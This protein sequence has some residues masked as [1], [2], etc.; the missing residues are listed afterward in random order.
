[1]P[2]QVVDEA[3]K[4]DCLSISYTY[5]EPTIFFEY[6]YDTARL[7]KKA[8]LGNI[9]VTN[10]FM[11]RQALDTI[12]P[13]LDAAN[14]DLKSYSEV[15]YK[16]NCKAH[17]QPVLDSIA[18]MKHLNIWVEVTTLVIPDQNDSEEELNEIASFIAKLDKDIPW[19]ISRFHPDYQF[20]DHI[21]TPIETLRRAREIGKKH[22]LRYVYLGNV[23]EGSETH[24]HKCNRLLI[25][26][27]YMSIEKNYIQNGRCPSCGIQVNG[28][29]Q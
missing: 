6:A 3:K 2:E 13:Y 14:V 24:C 4:H 5:T 12:K 25:K 22:G 7:A 15:Y 21:P 20:T 18:Y 26:R 17:L 1:M 8:G 29:W 27:A 9:F 19:H 23:L 11:T 16:Q 10:G 28:I